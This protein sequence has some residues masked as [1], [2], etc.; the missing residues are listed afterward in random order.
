MS[1]GGLTRLLREAAERWPERTLA[2]EPGGTTISYR[3][4]DRASDSLA[5]ELIEAGV[6]RGDRV[7]SV[8]NHPKVRPFNSERAISEPAQKADPIVLAI[9]Q[10]LAD[11]AYGPV[12]IDGISGRQTTD[13]I[14][15]FQLDQGMPVTG[16]INDNLITRLISVGAMA[17]N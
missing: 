17:Q 15:R 4:F 10:A 5:S 13:A 7:A 14:R 11:A 3:D 16:K 9:Q 1:T 6:A 8:T 12:A 2:E